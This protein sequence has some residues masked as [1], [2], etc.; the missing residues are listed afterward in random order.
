ML[1][2]IICVILTSW[3]PINVELFLADSVGEPMVSHV[4]FFLSLLFYRFV[5]DAECSGV[6]RSQRRW[7]L[8]VAQL[9]ECDSE[10]GS[11]SGVVKARAN[12]GFCCGSH[13]IFD[14]GSE[15]EDGSVK[16]L[17]LGGL[18][19]L[20]KRPPRRIRALETER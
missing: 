2:L 11:T 14:D 16:C 19:P 15:V 20:E 9:G 6:I 8:C 7:W 12:F 3:A 5:H 18:V 4:H 10:R 1:C 17:L 13:H